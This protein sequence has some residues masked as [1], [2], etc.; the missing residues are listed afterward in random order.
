MLMAWNFV[1][2]SA[3][4]DHIRCQS[5]LHIIYLSLG[6]ADDGENF[7]YPSHGNAVKGFRI[8]QMLRMR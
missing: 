2:T 3:P 5:P 8:L 6:A 7:E 4:L 1:S